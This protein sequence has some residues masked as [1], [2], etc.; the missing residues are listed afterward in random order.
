M[1]LFFM[2]D[3]YSG[4][5]PSVHGSPETVEIILVEEEWRWGQGRLIGQYLRE[6]FTR[7]QEAAGLQASLLY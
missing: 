5:E 2:V 3:I 4:G 7:S 1:L 6:S